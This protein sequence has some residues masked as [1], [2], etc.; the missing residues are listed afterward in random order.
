V[1]EG[2]ADVALTISLADALLSRYHNI[3][4][5]SLDKGFYCKEN[6]ELLSLYIPQL[7]MPKKSKLNAAEKGEESQKK[8]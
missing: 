4:S 3:E 6:K 1:I 5:L 7:V 8:F 2:N